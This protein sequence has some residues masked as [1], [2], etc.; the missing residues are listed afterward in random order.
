MQEWMRHSARL[1]VGVGLVLIGLGAR[2]L[3][4]KMLAIQAG[5]QAVAHWAQLQSLYELVGGVA[6]VGIGQGVTVYAARADQEPAQLLHAGLAWGVSVSVALA[7]LLLVCLPWV[8]LWT[9]RDLVPAPW[10][11]GLAAL[12]GVLSVVPGVFVAFWQGR[13]WRGRMLLAALAAW[14][15]LGLAVLGVFGEPDLATL[16]VV[17]CVTQGVLALGLCLSRREVLTAAH[18]WWRAPLRQYLPAGLSIGILSPLS[19][20]WVRGELAS[21]LSWAEVAQLQALW[22]TTEWVTGLAASVL[23][24]VFLPRLAVAAR[25]EAF[26]PTLRGLWWRLWLPA[27]AVLALI[28][29]Q[30]PVLLGW[31]YDERFLMPADISLLFIL[32]D[33]LRVAAWVPLLGLFASERIRPVAWGEWL[34]LPL[35]GVLITVSGGDSLVTAGWCHVLTYAVYLAFNSWCVYGATRRR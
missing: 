14:C 8:N 26:L 4:D 7:G 30:Q 35:F 13:A 19:L 34:S 31:L 25:S 6:L 23:F 9:G 2:A 12:A 32:G 5:P 15:P 22:R 27:V 1:L 24:L 3:I 21:Q 17:Q 29:W 11:A 33:A 20:V 18:P 10:L 28:G 16:L